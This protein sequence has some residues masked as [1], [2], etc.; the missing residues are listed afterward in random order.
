M[1]VATVDAVT[2][3]ATLERQPESVKQAAV[4][5]RLAITKT[6]LTGGVPAALTQ[7][8]AALNPLAPVCVAVLGAL[9]PAWLFDDH[10]FDLAERSSETRAWLSVAS[11]A[12]GHEGH[13]HTHDINRHDAAIACFA[14]LRDK[15]LPAI[16]LTLLLEI[17]AEHCGGDLLRL[18]G[19]VDLAESPGR[20]AVVH[21]VQHVFH[22]PVWL[23]AWPSADH[24]TRLVFIARKIPQ[25]WV[26][27][28]LAAIEAEIADVVA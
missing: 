24:R 7:R 20:P 2:G 3:L 22:A 26:E 17:L 8:L 6:D 13:R 12:A 14:I 15:P 28:V 23:D 25:A 10:L 16:A 4:A 18:K 5:D 27:A 1:P 9:D 21:G 19:L 11:E